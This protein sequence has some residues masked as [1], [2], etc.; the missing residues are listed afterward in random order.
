MPTA[1]TSSAKNKNK[2]IIFQNGVEVSESIVFKGWQPGYEYTKNIKLKN[3]NT[4]SVRLN[5]E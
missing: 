1:T 5:Y 3:L 2:N 4:K